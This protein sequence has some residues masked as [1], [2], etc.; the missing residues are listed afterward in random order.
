MNE[1]LDTRPEPAS[2]PVKPA[3][4][5]QAAPTQPGHPVRWIVGFLLLAAIA[6]GIY[7]GYYSS[8]RTPTTAAAGAFPTPVVTVSHPL[9]KTI[10]EWDEY[11]GQFQALDFVA[12]RARVSGYLTEIHFDDG[13][14][15]HKGDL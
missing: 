10:T 12:I 13:Q 3:P 14:F 7:Y 2:E 6:A 15:V 5:P 11:T 8:Q 4:A 9:Q 1:D